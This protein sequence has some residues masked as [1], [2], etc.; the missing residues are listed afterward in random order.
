MIE[1]REIFSRQNTKR[2]NSKIKLKLLLFENNITKTIDGAKIFTIHTS[3]KD[4]YPD[5]IGNSYKRLIK[6]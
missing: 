4:S 5:C 3:A 2:T 1:G 6:D